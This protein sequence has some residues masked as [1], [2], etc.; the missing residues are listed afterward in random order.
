MPMHFRLLL[1]LLPLI[2]GFA[3]SV[4][5]FGADQPSFRAQDAQIAPASKSQNPR[6]LYEDADYKFVGLHYG[7]RGEDSP[8][9]FAF[10]KSTGKWIRIS[11]VSTR[12]AVLGR[13][14]DSAK[15]PLQV[16]WD[17]SSL[18]EKEYAQF[19]LITNVVL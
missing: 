7:S 15:V 16:G 1:P 3:V 6:D 4:S 12:D 11:E 5:A 10:S 9:F 18:K 13:S 2:A 14:P 8:S 19:P 17:H